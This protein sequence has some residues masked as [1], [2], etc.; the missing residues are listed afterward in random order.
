[1]DFSKVYDLK[2]FT[3][4]GIARLITFHQEAADIFIGDFNSLRPEE[5]YRYFAQANCQLHIGIRNYLQS[6]IDGADSDIPVKQQ[7]VSEEKYIR[8]SVVD[9]RL[10]F[11]SDGFT[12]HELYGIL[13]SYAKKFEQN[14]VGSGMELTIKG[15][16]PIKKF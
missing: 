5:F 10:N 15:S 4:G 2:A 9:D 6:V 1:M 7:V 16:Q 13:S 14:I 12:M 8:V 11:D 3:K